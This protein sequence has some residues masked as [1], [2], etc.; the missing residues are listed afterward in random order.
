MTAIILLTTCVMQPA[1]VGSA[2]QTPLTWAQ[3]YRQAAETY[4]VT[5]STTGASDDGTVVPL[6]EEAVFDW[7][8]I[9]DFNGAVFAWTDEGRP[10]AFATIFSFALSGSQQ[11]QVVHEFAAFGDSPISVSGPAVAEWKTENGPVLQVLEH[12]PEPATNS[13][14]FKLQCRRLASE[15]SASLNR[16]GERWDLRLL[17]KPLLEYGEAGD[18][19]GGAVFAFVAYSTDPEILLRL[20]ARHSN[21]KVSWFF[22][23]VRFSDKSLYLSF[24]NQAIWESLRMG[25]GSTGPNTPDQLYR[26]L[27]SE[28][29][30]AETVE[31]LSAASKS[32]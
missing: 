30:S 27:H 20:E 29:L 12:A 5:R 13:K 18:C 19:L 7:S 25:H 15:F 16:K 21:G 4:V 8:S 31:Q 24:R 22:Q 3:F 2:V 6:A 17:P 23:P 32:E 11:R 26:V 14:L 1:P 9:D 10:V 28:R